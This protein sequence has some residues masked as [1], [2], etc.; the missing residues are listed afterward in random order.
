M[1]MLQPDT[2][3]HIYNRANGNENLFR[4]DKNYH[5]FLQQWAK[6]TSPIAE[7]YAYCLMPNHFHFL[8]KLRNEEELINFFKHKKK[9]VALTSFQDLSGLLSKQLSNLFNAYAKAYNKMYDRNGSLFCRPFKAKEISSDAY[10][11]NVIFYI[12]YNPVHHKFTDSIEAWEHSSYLALISEKDTRL[13]RAA[14]HD[15]F[16]GKDA[17]K[18]FHSQMIQGLEDMED[19]FT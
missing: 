7:T 3:Y 17:L 15:W 5:Y 6:Y 14:I 11:T 13:Q 2:Y 19:L 8:V 18:L 16:G 4:N 12:H 9:I 10:L 1:N